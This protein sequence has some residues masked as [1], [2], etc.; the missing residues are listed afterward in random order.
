M[1]VVGQHLTDRIKLIVDKGADV[2]AQDKRGYT[3][4]MFASGAIDSVDAPESA[5]AVIDNGARLS[6]QDR[7]SFTALMYTAAKRLSGTVRVLLAAGANRDTTNEEG[8]TALQLATA[9]SENARWR[10]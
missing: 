4:L 5:Q 3:P 8:K 6:M 2:N 1:Y 10:C 9:N 7:A